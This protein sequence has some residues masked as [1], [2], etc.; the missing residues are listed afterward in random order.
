MQRAVAHCHL[1][2]VRGH[3]DSSGTSGWRG[4][5]VW[6]TAILSTR[7]C[8]LEQRRQ[9]DAAAAPAPAGMI[10]LGDVLG[11]FRDAEWSEGVCPASAKPDVKFFVRERRAQHFPLAF[12]CEGPRRCDLEL[13]KSPGTCKFSFR[14]WENPVEKVKQ[15]TYTVPRNQNVLRCFPWWDD[16]WKGTALP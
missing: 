12:Q 1:M 6:K 5:K 14:S 13:N 4:T 2:V 11:G 10:V 7:G 3:V 9:S 16:F 8:T 15:C